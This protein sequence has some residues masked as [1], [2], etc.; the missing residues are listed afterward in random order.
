MISKTFV[1]TYSNSEGNCEP[2]FIELLVS[3]GGVI[4]NHTSMTAY[5]DKTG[6]TVRHS[7]CALLCDGKSKCGIYQ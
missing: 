5:L 2:D 1:K 3:R 6:N 7:K 4:R